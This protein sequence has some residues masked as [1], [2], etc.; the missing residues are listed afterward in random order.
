MGKVRRVT[1]TLLELMFTLPYWVKAGLDPKI[2]VTGVL[3]GR[4]TRL[5][6]EGRPEHLHPGST[7]QLRHPAERL[8]PVSHVSGGTIIP[9]PHLGTQIPLRLT[10]YPSCR[11]DRHFVADRQF[12]QGLSHMTHP[13]EELKYCPLRQ[14]ICLRIS[15]SQMPYLFL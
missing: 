12:A 8:L 4:I 11:Q 6:T 3:G 1:K 5:Q 15:F 2:G 7:L 10:S 9:S 14:P 13:T